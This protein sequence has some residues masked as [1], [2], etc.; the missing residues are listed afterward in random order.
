ML[1]APLTF[2]TSMITLRILKAI[3]A[4]FAS[5]HP[6]KLGKIDC[7][8]LPEICRVSKVDGCKTFAFD[9]SLVNADSRL[10]PVELVKDGEN[11]FLNRFLNLSRFRADLDCAG[12][13]DIED[14]Q[15]ESNQSP[16]YCIR[17]HV[18][19][20][21]NNVQNQGLIGSGCVDRVTLFNLKLN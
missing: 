15:V 19:K 5:T 9:L 2:I 17:T 11:L 14:S 4:G 1:D 20:V 21:K 13:E 18:M 6:A 3:F 12:D 8:N 16:C 10:V 7:T